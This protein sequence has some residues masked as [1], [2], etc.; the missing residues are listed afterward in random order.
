MININRIFVVVKETEYILPQ[1]IR[2]L[3]LKLHLADFFP[4]LHIED[5]DIFI[6]LL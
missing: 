3:F 6:G 2:T 4:A 1:S 5:T